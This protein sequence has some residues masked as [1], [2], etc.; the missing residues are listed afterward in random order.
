MTSLKE[1]FLEEETKEYIYKHHPEL[2]DI[3]EMLIEDD[4]YPQIFK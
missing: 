2:V 3:Y 4:N 1:I